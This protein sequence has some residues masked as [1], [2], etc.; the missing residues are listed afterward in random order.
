VEFALEHGA[1]IIVFEHLGTFKPEKGKYSRRESSKRWLRGRIC[2]YTKYKAWEHGRIKPGKSE[3][4]Q[5]V[6][7]RLRL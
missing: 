5:S 2:R 7:R 1:S 6:M 4:H 3:V